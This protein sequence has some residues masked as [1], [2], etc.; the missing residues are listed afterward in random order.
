V[1]VIKTAIVQQ[2]MQADYQANVDVSLSMI[3]EAAKNGADL[4][5]W[6]RLTCVV[7]TTH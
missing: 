6:C 3:R 5:K 2:Q 1:S 4:Q 7:R